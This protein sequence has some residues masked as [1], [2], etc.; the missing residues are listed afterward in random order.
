MHT[1]QRFID[2]D[3]MLS[4][5]DLRW[6][7]LRQHGH[8]RPEFGQQFA[9]QLRFETFYRRIDRQHTVGLDRHIT[10]LFSAGIGQLV[11]VVGKLEVT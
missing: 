5:D 8:Q 2:T 10:D 4:L 7:S 11:F 1:E 3:K 9:Y 6:Q